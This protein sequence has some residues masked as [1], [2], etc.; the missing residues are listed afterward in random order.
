MIFFYWMLHHYL[1]GVET[2]EIMTKL[3]TRG[4]TIPTKKTQVFSTAANNQPGVTIQV[5]EG[6]R[7]MTRDNNKLG[8]FQL[9]GI[10]PMPRGVPQ[11]EITYEVDAKGILNVSAVEKSTGKAE[12]ITISND[13][14]KLSKEDIVRL[15]EVAEKFKE[16]DKK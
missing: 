1:L 13:S 16:D 14:N 5:Y 12:K 3:I 4:T 11:I 6:E 15:V 7:T 8:E 2:S 9:S 10:P